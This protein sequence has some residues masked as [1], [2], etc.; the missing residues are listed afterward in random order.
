[1]RKIFFTALVGDYLKH[2]GY[3]ELFERNRPRFQSY[4]DKWGFELRMIKVES[5]P[6]GAGRHSGNPTWIKFGHYREVLDK[7]L[8]DGDCVFWCDADTILLR[9]DIDLT[10]KKDFAIS[11][12]PTGKLN[13]GIIAW[14]KGQFSK[15]LID[16][17]W[18]GKDE[19]TLP[20]YPISW[21]DQPNL[22]SFLARLTHHQKKDHIEIWPSYYN[23]TGRAEGLPS[24]VYRRLIFRHFAGSRPIEWA[25]LREPLRHGP[26]L[27]K[28]L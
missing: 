1:M 8:D 27:L 28:P 23:G 17:V 15:L 16:F 7:E 2:E 25:W 18:N 19:D 26:M 13:A 5:A 6:T 14:R 24:E 10:P 21:V 22:F 12:E 4:C 20:G 9:D 3:C 11:R